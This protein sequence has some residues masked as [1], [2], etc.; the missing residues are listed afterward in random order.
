M[1]TT[2][3]W[4]GSYLTYTLE[5]VHGSQCAR[6]RACYRLIRVSNRPSTA[7]NPSDGWS[8]RSHAGESVFF[9]C[10]RPILFA[11]A[12]AL[13]YYEAKNPISPGG[14]FTYRFSIGDQYGFYWYHSHFRTY[15]NDAIRGA[16]LIRPSSSRP[17]PFSMLAKNNADLSAL[18]QAE[19]DAK[20]VLLNDWTHE[21][22]DIIFAQYEKTGAFPNCVD[23]ILA[24]GQGRDQCLP[25]SVLQGGTGLGLATSSTNDDI[26]S[27]TQIS[28]G[29]ASTSMSGMRKRIFGRR[30]V[31]SRNGH[32]SFNCDL[33]D[34][35]ELSS[36]LQRHGI[37]VWNAQYFGYARY[38]GDTS[39]HGFTK[40]LWMYDA[41][42]VQARLQYQLSS[43]RDLHKHRIG[44]ADYSCQ[45]NARLACP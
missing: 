41:D 18:L 25:E 19:R 7:V 5:P 24:N 22:S 8:T 10:L 27:P 45:P 29:L 36:L 37:Y 4:H 13:A 44:L 17:R 35:K 20:S 12:L 40:P 43:T 6:S 38:V 21:L 23:S 16:L 42:D 30:Y 14:N 1:D 31:E 32:E 9:R 39:T 26:G 11:K 3:H 34:Y 28:M 15:Y 33:Y 2:I